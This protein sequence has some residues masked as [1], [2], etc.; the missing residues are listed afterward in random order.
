[1][2]GGKDY[3]LGISKLAYSFRGALSMEYLQD[4]PLSRI[5]ELNKH[6]DQIAKDISSGQ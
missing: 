3:Q 6:A 4:Q 5:V 2:L 1:V